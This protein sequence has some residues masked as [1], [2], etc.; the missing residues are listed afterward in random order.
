MEHT[1]RFLLIAVISG[2]CLLAIR[3]SQAQQPVRGPWPGP[4]RAYQRPVT[5]P[6]LGLLAAPGGSV[7]FEYFRRVRPELELRRETERLHRSLRTM[8][9][10][11]EP[12][13]PLRRDG[14]SQDG[15]LRPLTT[16]HSTS[17]MNRGNYFPNQRR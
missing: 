11:T 4:P 10:Q 12:D 17:F 8:R 9:Q 5:S 16:G 3:T 13:E 1:T 14:R 6:Y 15:T 2:I 7:E